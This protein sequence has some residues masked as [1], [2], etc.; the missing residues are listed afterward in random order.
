MRTPEARVLAESKTDC[1]VEALLGRP[2]LL[3]ETQAT[4]GIAQAHFDYNILA[5]KLRLVLF[6]LLPLPSTGR[7]PISSASTVVGSQHLNRQMS[8]GADSKHHTH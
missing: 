2:D 1:R 7:E 6:G 8:S 3:T 5:A 4:A